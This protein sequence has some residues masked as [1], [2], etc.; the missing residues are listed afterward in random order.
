MDIEGLGSKLV[1]Q[2]VSESLVSNPAEVY[3]LTKKQLLGLERMGE[4]SAEKLLRSIERSKETTFARFLFALGVRGVGAA[5]ASTLAAR[6][7]TLDEL[8][9]ADDEVLQDVE[10]IGPIVANQ[11]H[12]FF[13]ESHNIQVIRKL[14]EHGV[15]WP[16]TQRL[17]RNTA[18]LAGKRVVVTG[19]LSRL[20]RGEVKERLQQLGAKVTSSVS[21]NTD[22]VIV[23]ENPGTKLAKAEELGVRTIDEQAASLEFGL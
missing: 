8:M 17:I 19:T 20:S 2:L 21:R 16:V 18:P 12:T 7:E 1:E 22:L 5:T 10:D 13:H 9:K 23:G 14:V 11:I 6:F 4:K 15:R 3:E